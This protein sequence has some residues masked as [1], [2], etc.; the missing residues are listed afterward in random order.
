[1]NRLTKIAV[2][3]AAATFT[4]A[5]PAAATEGD[6]GNQSCNSGYTVVIQ[7]RSR[8]TTN[9]FYPNGTLKKTYYNYSSWTTN[10]THTFSSSTSWGVVTTQNNFLDSLDQ[11]NTYAYCSGFSL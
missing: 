6:S 8:D 9:V 10:T 5:L 3:A 11:A 4:T 1:M 7:S 2:I